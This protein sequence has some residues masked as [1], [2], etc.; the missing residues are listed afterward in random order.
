MTGRIIRTET[1][2]AYNYLYY[3]IYFEFEFNKSITVTHST[4]TYYTEEQYSTHMPIFF[5]NNVFIQILITGII[6]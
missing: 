1:L 6:K 4:P 3:W 2:F 5:F